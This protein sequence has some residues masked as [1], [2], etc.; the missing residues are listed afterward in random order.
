MGVDRERARRRPLE[1]AK[2]PTAVNGALDHVARTVNLYAAAGVPLDHLKF[3]AVVS[4]PATPVVLNDAQYKAAYG[5]ANPNL[6]LIA[7]LKKAG[8][9]SPSAARRSPSTTSNTIGST[10]ASPSR[11]PR[12]PR[13]PRWSIRATA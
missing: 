9:T 5:V 1:G 8:W 6:A 3:V 10:R 11:C 12:S 7:E 2:S 4:G 13:S